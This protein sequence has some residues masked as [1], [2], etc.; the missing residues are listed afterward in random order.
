MITRTQLFTV[1][2]M[3]VFWLAGCTMGQGFLVAPPVADPAA[4]SIPCESLIATAVAG[5]AITET[6][7]LTTTTTV[8]LTPPVTATGVITIAP[9]ISATVTVTATPPLT[10]TPPITGAPPLTAT[11]TLTATAQPT[12]PVTTT[13][14]I[15][16]TLTPATPV[17]P[18]RPLTGTVQPTATAPAPETPGTP[19]APVAPTAPA[20]TATQPPTITPTRTNTPAPTATATA[21]STPSPTVTPTA[22][23]TPTGGPPTETPTPAPSGTVYVRSH[24]GFA[25]DGAFHV[26]GEVVNATAGAVFRVRVV[27]SFFNDSGQM[28]ATQ[29]AYGFLVQTEP[30]QRNPFRM[31]VDNLGGEITRYELAVHW[32]DISVVTFA[33][34]AVLSAEMREN[35][36]DEVVGELQ[37]DFNEN[38]GSLVVVVT[39]YDDAGNVIDAYQSAPRATQLA[40]GE[41]TSYEVL[42][43]PDLPVATFT[44]QAQG[45]RAIF[46]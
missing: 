31:R 6:A 38:L 42:V 19:R 44:V 16:G 2:L 39:L 5:A 45:R 30:E 3:F 27:G 34:L 8:T 17:T 11:V 41:T 15:T 18:T 36:G 10:A 13:P 43:T 29:E 24:R 7:T 40:P 33:D 22:T 1:G 37:N 23:A 21:T 26:A 28:L 25:R 20:A 9:P 4:T 12:Q 14:V 32:E 46:F 35:N